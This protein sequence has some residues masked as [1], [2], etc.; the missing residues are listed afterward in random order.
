MFRTIYHF[1]QCSQILFEQFPSQRLAAITAQILETLY[2]KGNG[3]VDANYELY[4]FLP[5]N[6]FDTKPEVF[7]GWYSVEFMK[8]DA[9]CFPVE[10]L[11]NIDYINIYATISLS[12]RSMESRGKEGLALSESSIRVNLHLALLTD[13]RILPQLET[14]YFLISINN[15][16]ERP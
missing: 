4:S 7:P 9:G 11:F 12:L 6:I 10:T 13:Q 14:T 5:L 2:V 1:Y 15:R 8:I 16:K 3:M